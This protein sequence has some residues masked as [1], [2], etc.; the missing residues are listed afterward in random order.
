MT[1]VIVIIKRTNNKISILLFY[2]SLDIDKVW[3][4]LSKITVKLRLLSEK[5]K[6]YHKFLLGNHLKI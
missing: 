4:K 1:I 3:Q 6:K 5:E 2:S